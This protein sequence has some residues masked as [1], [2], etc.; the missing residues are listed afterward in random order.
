VTIVIIPNIADTAAKDRV[1]ERAKVESDTPRID[2]G[3]FTRCLKLKRHK[4]VISVHR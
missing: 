1:F 4:T 2:R 3:T